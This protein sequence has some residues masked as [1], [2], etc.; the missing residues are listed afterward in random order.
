MLQY[1]PLFLILLPGLKR[2]NYDLMLNTININSKVP[3]TLAQ[4]QGTDRTGK[5]KAEEHL[6]YTKHCR[7]GL[8]TNENK[9]P[10][11]LSCPEEREV[12]QGKRAQV[13]FD[14]ISKEN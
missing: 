6:S 3:G 13:I 1:I 12:Q 4:E 14:V 7:K 8:Q 10:A 11:S 5:K 9:N 2:L